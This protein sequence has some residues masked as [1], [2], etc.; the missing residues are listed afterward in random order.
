MRIA[1]GESGSLGKCLWQGEALSADWD[2]ARGELV[3]R[4]DADSEAFGEVIS[5]VLGKRKLRVEIEDAGTARL[6][7]Q[8]YVDS[9]EFE[10]LVPGR[11]ECLLRILLEDE[12]G[13][14]GG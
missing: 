2:V 4:G 3:I 5:S 6:K 10:S 12:P 1:L 13:H 9:V 8:G 7:W 14:G 11:A